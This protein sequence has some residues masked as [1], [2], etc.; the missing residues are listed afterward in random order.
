MLK[1]FISVLIRKLFQSYVDES[2]KNWKIFF[3][4][5]IIKA[6]RASNDPLM[7][8]QRNKNMIKRNVNNIYTE[9]VKVR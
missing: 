6:T 7:L 2:A 1:E 3:F 8:I 5:F 4:F 9:D